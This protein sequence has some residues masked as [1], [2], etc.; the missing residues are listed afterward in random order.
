MFTT[1]LDASVQLTLLSPT[2]IAVIHGGEVAKRGQTDGLRKEEV[3]EGEGKGRK[4]ERGRKAREGKG[5]MQE[6][7]EER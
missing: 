1:F 6:E 4:K 3:W 5:G 2:T 7:G